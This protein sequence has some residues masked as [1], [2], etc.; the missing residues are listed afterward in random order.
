MSTEHNDYILE[1]K[2]LRRL[3]IQCVSS[4]EA[5]MGSHVGAEL[6]PRFIKAL[7][8]AIDHLGNDE[9]PLPIWLKENPTEVLSEEELRAAA[10]KLSAELW[11]PKS[12][13][14]TG[15]IR[16]GMLIA[17]IGDLKRNIGFN[18]ELWYGL[19][20]GPRT[21]HLLYVAMGG[22]VE[23]LIRYNNRTNYPEPKI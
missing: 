23:A 4:I 14:I 3:I 13:V 12:R 16:D 2:F 19:S 15:V 5:V 22:A 21:R 18:L 7:S 17:G 8:Y 6:F 20:T 1:L 10:E 9:R 11:G